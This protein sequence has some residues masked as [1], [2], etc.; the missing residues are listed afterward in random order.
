[1]R[2]SNILLMLRACRLRRRVFRYIPRMP[3]F[4]RGKIT[5]YIVLPTWFDFS[6][7]VRP[8]MLRDAASAAHAPDSS[9]NPSSAIFPFSLKIKF[10]YFACFVFGMIL[11]L[12][13][14]LKR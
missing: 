1:M 5:F 4:F 3:S 12:C 13:N 7:T 14:F 2:E 10:L 11:Y 8:G 9:R 6:E